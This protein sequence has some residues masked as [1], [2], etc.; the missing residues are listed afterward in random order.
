MLLERVNLSKSFGDR[1]LFSGGFK[2]E[3]QDKIGLIGANG[4][5]KTTLFKIISGEESAD[6]GGI[7]KASGTSVGLLRQHACEGSTKTALDEALTVFDNVA[8]LESELEDIANQLHTSSD[9][10]LIEK[11]DRLRIEFERLGGLTYKARTKAALLGLGFTETELSL[12]VEKLSGGQKS[13]IELAKLLLS[14]PDI[15][16]LDEPTNHL[17]IDAIEWLDSFIAASKSAAVI[18][19]HDRYFLDRVATKIISI[20]HEKIYCYS[21]NYTKYLEQKELRELSVKREYDNTMKEV[22]RIEGIIEQ[23]KRW[24]RE[25]NIKTA[26]SKQKQIDRMLEGLVIPESEKENMTLSFKADGMCGNEVLKVKNLSCSFSDRTLYRDVSVDMRRGD[27]VV[28]LGRNGC[29]K[30]TLLKALL[31]SGGF[32]VG[33]T[34]GYF[35]QHGE[36]LDPKKT[37]FTQLRDTFPRKTDTEL[38]CALALFMFRGD[39]VFREIGTLSGGERARVALCSL[40]LKRDNFLLLDEPT[41]HLD[42]ESREILE[43]ALNDYDGTILAVSHDRYFINRIAKRILY[44]KGEALLTLNGNYDSYLAAKESEQ[45]S[46]EKAKAVGAGKAVYLQKKAD[47]AAAAKLRSAISSAEKRIEELEGEICEIEAE[48]SSPEVS[49]DYEKTGHLCE[50]LEKCRTELA[51]VLDKWEELSIEAEENIN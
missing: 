1:L 10:A 51:A 13:K 37:I 5:G 30:T 35:D 2:I 41:N 48:L 9:L 25:K 45:K 42:L 6:S 16:L 11:A 4:V 43:N 24:N 36:G 3:P 34:V 15:M 12:S 26:E 22:H 31:K 33:V 20:E 28:M 40:M 18:I 39:E 38:R 21:G 50:S 8:Q 32:G 49:S 44:F 46:E 23:Q 47:R 7:V 27:R 19:S 14:S 29:G 17:D